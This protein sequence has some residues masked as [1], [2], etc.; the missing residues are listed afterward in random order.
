MTEKALQ[1]CGGWSILYAYGETP[2]VTRQENLTSSF[3]Q[4]TDG[5]GNGNRKRNT[6]HER[7]WK[8]ETGW[9][10]KEKTGTGL[11]HNPWLTKTATKMPIYA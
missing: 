3:K 4:G 2:T 5:I 7:R 6:G 10:W 8:W 1:H 11:I 9:E